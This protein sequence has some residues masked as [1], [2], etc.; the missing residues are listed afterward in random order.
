MENW[1]KGARPLF[2]VGTDTGV[3][4]TVL[5][6]L[7]MQF[8]FRNGYRPFYLKPVQTGCKDPG[9]EESDARFVY[10][11]T[12]SLRGGDPADSVVYCFPEPKAPLIAARAAGKEI[13]ATE[14]GRAVAAKKAGYSP[15]IVEAAG[16]V[17]VPVTERIL[18][19]DLI[20]LLGA[21]PVIAARAGLGTINHT[22][23][24]IEAL[25]RRGHR[26]LGV[27]FIDAGER[28]T[29]L[30]MVRENSA[31]VESASGVEV[32]GVIG[33]IEDFSRPSGDCFRSLEKIFR[34]I[35]AG[36]F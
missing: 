6:L 31:A 16:G 9:D 34:R 27:V 13:D 21:V 20:G 33:R 10:E 28:E 5:S 26:P 36:R 8:F 17:L 30:A 19:A 35:G 15:V 25:E 18:V 2:V 7:M 22:L 24:T 29:P 4:K 1:T 11:H 23:L 3:G 12:D 32:A 14:I